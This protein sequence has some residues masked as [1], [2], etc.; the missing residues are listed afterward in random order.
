MCTPRATQHRRQR[1]P[2][3]RRQRI[4]R[5]RLSL[6]RQQIHR[7]RQSLHHQRSQA[8]PLILRPWIHHRAP[9]VVTAVPV[10]TPVVATQRSCPRRE[11]HTPVRKHCSV[12]LLPH[13]AL[14]PLWLDAHAER[15]T[16]T[17]QRPCAAQWPTTRAP[18]MMCGALVVVFCQGCEARR[19]RPW[20]RIP[21]AHPGSSR[22][23][24]PR[25]HR[26]GPAR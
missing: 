6:H 24:Q 3:A 19:F 1:Q 21:R 12:L 18:H 23:A 7:H 15:I 22:D 8:L 25:S 9:M 10:E 14:L 11:L 16:K 26:R 2:I 17:R 5:H 20:Y 13:L 4:R